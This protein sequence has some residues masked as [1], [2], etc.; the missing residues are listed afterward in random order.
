MKQENEVL[1]SLE[2]LNLVSASENSYEF[3][4]LRGDGRPTGV[5]I[6]VLGSQAPKVQE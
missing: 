1:F 6:S 2:E 3:E 4:Y 5:F